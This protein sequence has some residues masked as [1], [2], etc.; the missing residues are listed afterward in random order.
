MALSISLKEGDVA[1]VTYHMDQCV[2]LGCSDQQIYET[3]NVAA[4][5]GGGSAM[6]QAVTEGIEVLKQSRSN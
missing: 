4:A 2:N 5:Y 1:S 6:T 3:I